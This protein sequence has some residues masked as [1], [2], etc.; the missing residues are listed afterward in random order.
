MDSY[1]TIGPLGST[2]RRCPV[3]EETLYDELH[4]DDSAMKDSWGDGNI[5]EWVRTLGLP[6]GDEKFSLYGRTRLY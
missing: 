2:D 6:C 3:N 1:P 5:K 4:A